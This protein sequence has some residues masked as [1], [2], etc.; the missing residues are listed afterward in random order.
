MTEPFVPIEDLAKHFTVSISTVR[1]WV[2]QGLIPKET[3]IKVGNTYRFSVS[4]VVEALT[5]APKDE[6]EKVEAIVEEPD[7]PVQLELDLNPDKDI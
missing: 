3:Y 2:R 1:A 7:T 5:S 6:P 4:K